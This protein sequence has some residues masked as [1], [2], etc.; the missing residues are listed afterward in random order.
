MRVNENVVLTASGDRD[1][2]NTSRVPADLSNDSLAE[3]CRLRVVLVEHRG[4]ES[5]ALKTVL[6]RG[7]CEVKCAA[8]SEAVFVAA[9]RFAPTLIIINADMPDQSGWL[10]AAK[11]RLGNYREQMWLYVSQQPCA[12]AN[13]KEFAGV[14][15]VIK[16]DALFTQFLQ[17]VEQEIAD[18]M[19]AQSAAPKTTVGR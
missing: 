15:K 6:A 3:Q 14:D 12:T 2:A 4:A 5:A 13:W 18:L 17:T 11:L 9:S 19:A 16:H 1:C 8:S 10:I 7:G